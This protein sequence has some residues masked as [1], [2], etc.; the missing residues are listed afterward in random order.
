MSEINLSRHEVEGILTA[1]SRAQHTAGEAALEAFS[2]IEHLL[3]QASQRAKSKAMS[4][5][6]DLKDLSELRQKALE[7]FQ[8]AEMMGKRW[9]LPSKVVG[10]PLKTIEKPWFLLE[11]CRKHEGNAW[12]RGGFGCP[13]TREGVAERGAGAGRGALPPPGV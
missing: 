4:E 2:D 8:A 7:A 1:L 12:D 11:K 13:G 6:V 3:Q 5:L 10:K 9:F